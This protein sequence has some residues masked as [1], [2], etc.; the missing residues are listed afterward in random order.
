VRA[1]PGRARRR[2]R[3]SLSL[4]PHAVLA[5]HHSVVPPTAN[6]VERSADIP[7]ALRIVTGSPEP[8][9]GDARALVEGTRRAH[10]SNDARPARRRAGLVA[11]LKNSFGFGGV[12]A[13]LLFARL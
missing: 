9:P 5:L 12:N 6:L 4:A 13:C 11:A 3:S 1:R 2:A 8:A 7:A 10:P